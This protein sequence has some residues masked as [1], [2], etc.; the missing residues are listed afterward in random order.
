MHDQIKL[1]NH[2]LTALA[3]QTMHGYVLEVLLGA[4]VS[5]NSNPVEALKA[6]RFSLKAQA[7][8]DIARGLHTDIFEDK[9]DFVQASLLSQIDEMFDR[10]A[11][12]YEKPQ[13][14]LYSA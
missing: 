8:D 1:T 13:K 3:A 14:P 5:N 2:E 4:S 10:V 12:H 7:C 6:L 11:S 9:T